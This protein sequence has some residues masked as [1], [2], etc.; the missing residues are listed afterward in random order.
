MPVLSAAVSSLAAP[1]AAAA[2][3]GPKALVV[4]V[5][6]LNSSLRV[7][8]VAS[9]AAEAAGLAEGEVPRSA[10]LSGGRGEMFVSLQSFDQVRAVL[11]GAAA[12]RKDLL[13][14]AQALAA[15]ERAVGKVPAVLASLPPRAATALA[16]RVA[17]GDDAAAI[18]LL[19]QDDA[20]SPFAWPAGSLPKLGAFNVETYAHFVRTRPEV[21]APGVLDFE[22]EGLPADLLDGCA[23]A[24]RASH[25]A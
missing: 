22:F 1:Q 24:Q 8:A 19:A 18:A 10:V 2:A 21:F 14:G 13:A 3:A 23:T 16:S 12:Q 15:A 17:A 11:A 6:G 25:S 7:G 4:R 9:M 5:Y 20:M